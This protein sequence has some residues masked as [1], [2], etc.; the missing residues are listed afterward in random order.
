MRTEAEARLQEQSLRASIEAEARKLGFRNPADAHAFIDLAAVER[1]KDGE[2]TNI[3]KLLT[4]LAKERE[5]LL[6]T[7]D[8]GGGPRGTSPGS[9]GP[10]MNDIIRSA[11]SRH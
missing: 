7:T 10:T 2:P 8:F 5:Y 1:S 11:A 6:E 3:D 9:S 4:D